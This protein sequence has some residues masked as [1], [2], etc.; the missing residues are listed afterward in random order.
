MPVDRADLP[1]ALPPAHKEVLDQLTVIRAA[2]QLTRRRLQQGRRL[3]RARLAADLARIEACV[4]AAAEVVRRM[5]AHAPGES[6]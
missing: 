5:A 1:P 3:D 6:G 4:D 2:A